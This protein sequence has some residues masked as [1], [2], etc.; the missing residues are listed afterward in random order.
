MRKISWSNDWWSWDQLNHNTNIFWNL[1]RKS[2]GSP[3]IA[4]YLINWTSS[5]FLEGELDS[6][7]LDIRDVNVFNSIVVDIFHDA[8]WCQKKHRKNSFS[9]SIQWC[10]PHLAT[11]LRSGDIKVSY[12]AFQKNH[13]VCNHEFM[14]SCF[15]IMYYCID[16]IL[17]L[18]S[19]NMKL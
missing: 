9:C 4:N 7:F 14:Q 11:M 1:S 15:Y 5:F 6:Q 12:V 8:S 10:N 13:T 2:Q 3:L 17:W 16:V 18:Y 19:F